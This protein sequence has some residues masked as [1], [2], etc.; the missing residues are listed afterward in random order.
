MRSPQKIAARPGT[1]EISPAGA[2]ASLDALRPIEGRPFVWHTV[3]ATTPTQKMTLRA[4]VGRVAPLEAMIEA[5]NL[6]PVSFLTQ[7][8][9]SA[10]A[11]AQIVVPQLGLGT[12]FMIADD[13]LM[14]NNHVLPTAAVAGNAQARFNYEIDADGKLSEGVYFRLRPDL[15]FTTNEKLDYSI[16]AVEGS[17]GLRFGSIALERVPLGP[18]QG[19]NIVQHPA[20]GPKQVALVDNELVYCD[21]VLAQYLTDTLPGSSGSP[22]FDDNWR[23]VALHNSGGWIPEPGTQS[24]HFRNQGIL[25]RAILDDLVRQGFAAGH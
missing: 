19:F 4:I 21:E 12:G 11:V 23:L 24:T 15:F 10:R 2:P 14:T 9:R 17:P 22:V 1:L 13:C 16:V 5:N 3:G 8:I 25:V 7:A 6:R 20:G 18:N